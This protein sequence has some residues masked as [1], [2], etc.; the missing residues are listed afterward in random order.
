MSAADNLSQQRILQSVNAI[1]A[2]KALAGTRDGLFL[3]N[4]GVGGMIEYPWT[5]LAGAPSV[6]GTDTGGGFGIAND[7]VLTG[8]CADNLAS[9][10]GSI[11]IYNCPLFSEWDTPL[12]ASIAGRLS[13][14][15][16]A[17][18]V[19]ILLPSLASCAGTLEIYDHA[20]METV[21]LSALASCAGTLKIYEN[22]VLAALDFPVLT[23]VAGTLSIYHND[24]IESVDL[25]ALASANGV[26]IY[27]NANLETLELSALVTAGYVSIYG[28][29]SLV[30]LDLSSLTTVNSFNGYGNTS[31]VAL[32]LSSLTTVNSFNG[33]GN[34]ALAS[35]DFSALTTAGAFLLDGAFTSVSFPSLVTHTDS[36]FG[37]YGTTPNLITIT[38]GALTTLGGDLIVYNN[39]ALTT[40]NLPGLASITA[41]GSVSAW[42]NP[43]LTDVS[44]AAS[45]ATGPGFTIA[46][47]GCALNTASVD[48]ILSACAAGI[49][50]NTV[51]TI[52]LSGGTNSSPTG[53]VANADYLTLT[54]AGITV[55]I[56]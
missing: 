33:Y 16:N 2:T 47:Q 3:D 21:D 32:D 5:T 48:A 55:N 52:N 12:I 44:M 22:A 49:G 31:L 9:L 18:L 38:F 53:G 20:A 41:T 24:G 29:T 30:A 45:I 36:F 4:F 54:A 35:V 39:A 27:D 17:A 42:D 26:S 14:Y 43:V 6:A 34:T 7:S 25:P 28:N 40:L 1:L 56:N 11:K 23:S 51:G 19:E 8:F 37:V 46:L 13:V 15:T 50:G 10:E